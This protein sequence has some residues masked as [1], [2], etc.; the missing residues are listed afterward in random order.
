MNINE[1][2]TLY[3]I[4]GC[5]YLTAVFLFNKQNVINFIDVK[6]HHFDVL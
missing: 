2:W 5:L 6:V 4:I 3:E 1:I